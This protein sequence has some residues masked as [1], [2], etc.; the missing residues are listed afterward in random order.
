V[1]IALYQGEVL[2][3]PVASSEIAE[4]VWFGPDSDWDALSPIL[5][6]QIIPDCIRRG[7]LPWTIPNP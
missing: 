7:I 2:G 5:K 4:L 3:E 1:Q 6:N